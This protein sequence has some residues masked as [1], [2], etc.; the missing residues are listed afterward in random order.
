MEDIITLSD[1]ADIVGVPEEILTGSRG[2]REITIPRHLYWLY[3]NKAR[4]LSCYALAKYFGT[5]A[6]NITS[7]VRSIKNLIDTRD[8]LVL[9]YMDFI[10]KNNL[11]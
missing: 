11:A 7:G 10:E 1:Y 2:K 4:K 3:L 5:S 6:W 8:P 9:P